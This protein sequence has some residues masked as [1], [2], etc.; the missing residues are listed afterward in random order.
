[1]DAA[2]FHEKGHQR[3]TV[4]ATAGGVALIV[5]VGAQ[6]ALMRAK[7]TPG[8]AIC[9]RADG[10]NPTN[11]TGME[12]EVGEVLWFD[13]SLHQFKAIRRDGTNVTLV[14]AYYGP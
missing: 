10:T 14:V 12:L 3:V 11:S 9:Y 5:P 2:I 13:A 7:G 1:M 6:W 4:D 8:T